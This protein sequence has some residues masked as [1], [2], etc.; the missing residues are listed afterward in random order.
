MSPKTTEISREEF[1]R[2]WANEV[3]R[4]KHQ[5]GLGHK[6]IQEIRETAKKIPGFESDWTDRCGNIDFLDTLASY[7]KDEKNAA[8][9]DV[10]NE[11]NSSRI[12]QTPGG[13]A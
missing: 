8:I 1:F 3:D 4:T 12:Q 11:P 10:K 9:M 5:L 13:A 7:L 6:T 2:E